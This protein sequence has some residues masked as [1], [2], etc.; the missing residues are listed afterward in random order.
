MVEL[1]DDNTTGSPIMVN[2]ASDLSAP[3]SSEQLAANLSGWGGQWGNDTS[4]TLPAD[5]L[6]PFDMPVVRA[7]FITLYAVVFLLC[8]VGESIFDYK[9][10]YF[11]IFL[12]IIW[13]RSN[14]TLTLHAAVFLLCVVG[15][16]II[17]LIQML[18]FL[19]IY[20]YIYI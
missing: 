6:N 12:H 4:W 3:S 9:K 17:S 16:A 10:V 8:V 13:G 7:V 18:N 2:T 19:H 11:F 5:R 1:R 15:E 14:F 20:I